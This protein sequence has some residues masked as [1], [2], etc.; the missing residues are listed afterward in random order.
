MM[1]AVTMM[2][3]AKLKE[4]GLFIVGIGVLLG[5]ELPLLAVLLTMLH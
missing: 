5:I 3:M 4:F 2:L 1:V